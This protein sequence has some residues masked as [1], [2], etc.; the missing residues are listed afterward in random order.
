M[1]EHMIASWENNTPVCPTCG[2]PLP[3]MRTTYEYDERKKERVPVLISSVLDYGVKDG[4]LWF[5]RKCECASEVYY[6]RMIS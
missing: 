1:S 6:E 5:V 2:K 4:A 3:H